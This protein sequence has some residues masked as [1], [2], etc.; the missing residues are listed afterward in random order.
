MDNGLVK[1]VAPIDDTPAARAG[2]HTIQ[3]I[4]NG[5]PQPKRTF[6]SERQYLPR[7]NRVI[8]II[9][10]IL[11]PSMDKADGEFLA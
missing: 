2:I 10:L 11:I 8:A 1:V 6:F 9:K 3:F 7:V 4:E 5:G